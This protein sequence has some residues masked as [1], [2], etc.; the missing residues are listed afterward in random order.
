MNLSDNGAKFIAGHEG[1]VLRAYNDPAGLIGRR[2]G[3]PVL[4]SGG[5]DC[6]VWL[7]GLPALRRN[8]CSGQLE[9]HPSSGVGCARTRDNAVVPGP[10][11]CSRRRKDALGGNGFWPVSLPN[12]PDSGDCAMSSRVDSQVRDGRVSNRRDCDKGDRGSGPLESARQSFP[13]Q[14][15]GIAAMPCCRLE[16]DRSLGRPETRSIPSS[17]S[18]RFGICAK[19]GSSGRPEDLAVSGVVS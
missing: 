4:L 9:Q 14:H 5:T 10:T 11:G 7:A 18:Q 3:A 17:H 12:W 2:R 19:A 13:K 1:M 6:S 8:P 16:S 15:G